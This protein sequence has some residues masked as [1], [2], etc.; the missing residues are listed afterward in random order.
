VCGLINSQSRRRRRHTY[1]RPNFNLVGAIARTCVRA[2]LYP[3][4]ICQDSP[5]PSSAAPCRQSPLSVAQEQ[6][7]R[8]SS[9]GHGGALRWGQPL[10]GGGR[11]PFL[12]KPLVQNQDPFPPSP[13]CSGSSSLP[14]SLPWAYG[15][16]LARVRSEHG[17]DLTTPRRR[18]NPSIYF[19]LLR[20]PIL[21]SPTLLVL[22]RFAVV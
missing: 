8:G 19:L 15:E 2:L 13:G 3:S 12:G 16:V 17:A 1:L 5:S 9:E 18:I 22:R 10:R 11:E 14:F 21:P 4:S 20:P 7:R 6:A